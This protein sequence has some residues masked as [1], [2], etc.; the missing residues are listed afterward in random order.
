MPKSVS[1][2][3]ANIRPLRIKWESGANP[4]QSRCCDVRSAECGTR[5]RPYMP[6]TPMCGR[7]GVGTGTSQKTCRRRKI[8]TC[9]GQDKSDTAATTVSVLTDAALHRTEPVSVGHIPPVRAAALRRSTKIHLTFNYYR[10][11]NYNQRCSIQCTD[12]QRTCRFSG[13]GIRHIG[14]LR[15]DR[16]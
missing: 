9:E 4:E 5:F 8:A 11:E 2:T 6:L 15:F 12:S 3:G 14:I 16:Q 13:T 1:D 7:E 10:N